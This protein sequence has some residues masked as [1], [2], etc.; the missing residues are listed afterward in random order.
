[1]NNILL[2]IFSFIIL[3]IFYF[4]LT[5]F[6]KLDITMDMLNTNQ[7]TIYNSLNFFRLIIYFVILLLVQYNINIKELSNNYGVKQHLKIIFPW[8]LIFGVFIIILTIFPD[9]VRVFSGTIGLSYILNNGVYILNQILMNPSDF[10]ELKNS[11]DEGTIRNV[12]LTEDISNM[13]NQNKDILLEQ[14]TPLN[15]NNMFNMLSPIIRT[16]IN[17]DEY[18]EDLLD[19][20][21]TK[22]NIG[23]F[24]WYI[25]IG[26][27]TIYVVYLNIRK[28][29]HKKTNVSVE[30]A[31]ASTTVNNKKYT[32]EDELTNPPLNPKIKTF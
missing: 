28:K 13:I 26:L 15:F 23:M 18:K 3:T 19:L 12:T 1:M 7:I 2:S 25:Y 16:D 6:G 4:T 30:T 8:L 20:I 17:I 5:T 11:F 14:L 9:I 10:D 21:V 31:N 32:K 24:I 27:F 22:N 29:K